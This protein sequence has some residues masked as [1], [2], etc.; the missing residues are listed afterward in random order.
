MIS[1]PLTTLG[2]LI[3]EEY[4]KIKNAVPGEN[5]ELPETSEI[6]LPKA[7]FGISK[8]FE[9]HYDY[10]LT[11]AANL[12]MEFTQTNDIISTS[13]ASINPAVRFRIWLYRFGFL[14]CWSWEFSTN[15]TN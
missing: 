12:N 5:Q 11:T 4:E 9:F 3:E 8:K 13:V 1:L 10:T 7:Q 6:T 14:A 2:A 15:Y